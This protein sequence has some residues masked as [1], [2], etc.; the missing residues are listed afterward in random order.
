MASTFAEEYPDDVPTIREM[1]TD[2]LSKAVRKLI[3]E[4]GERVDGRN[5]H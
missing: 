5:A 2:L 4:E 3:I 1:L